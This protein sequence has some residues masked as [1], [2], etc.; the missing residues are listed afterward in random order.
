MCLWR[1]L[2]GNGLIRTIDFDQD[3]EA[4]GGSNECG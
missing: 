3:K 2:R 1:S 4:N